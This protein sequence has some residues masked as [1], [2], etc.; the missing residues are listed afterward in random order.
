MRKFC[1]RVAVRNRSNP[2][3]LTLTP[4]LSC[5]SSDAWL[6]RRVLKNSAVGTNIVNWS[7]GRTAPPGTSIASNPGPSRNCLF[8]HVPAGVGDQPWHVARDKVPRPPAGEPA[9]IG[10]PV[11]DE[12]DQMRRAPRVDLLEYPSTR[13]ISA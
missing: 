11:G 5:R 9:E 8:K 3:S 2:L 7:L 12:R 10:Q 1:R 4:Y 13:F 6:V